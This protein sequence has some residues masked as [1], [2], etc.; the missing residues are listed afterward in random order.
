[1]LIKGL[2]DEDFCNFKECSMFIVFPYCSFKCGKAIC[3]NS[4]LVK[5]PNIE[6]SKEEICERYCQNPL[7]KA[8]V[9]GGLEPFD[10][11]TEVGALINCLRNRYQCDDYIVIYSGYTE[12]EFTDPDNTQLYTL[13][14]NLKKY[15]NIIIKFGRYIPG[16]KAH[17]DPILGVELISNNQYAIKLT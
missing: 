8:M 10:S 1:M 9:L 13:Y 15:K 14:N 16:Q 4:S 2:V 12:E 7:S 11:P 17:F 3:Q 5:E 6:I